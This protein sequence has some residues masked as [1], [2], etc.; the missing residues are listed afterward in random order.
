ME[1]IPENPKYDFSVFQLDDGHVDDGISP[2]LPSRNSSS[3]S[4]SEE[5]NDVAGGFDIETLS[6]IIQGSDDSDSDEGD[7]DGESSIASNDSVFERLRLED[8]EKEEQVR[9]A[10]TMI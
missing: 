1:G 9:N 5:D 4:L 10:D 8:E 7:G 2:A 3:S 6:R